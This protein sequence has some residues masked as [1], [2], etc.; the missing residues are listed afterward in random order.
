[1]QFPGSLRLRTDT[2]L[3]VFEEVCESLHHH[4]LDNV[5]ASTVTVETSRR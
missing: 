2:F 3:H 5:I 1:M 4:G